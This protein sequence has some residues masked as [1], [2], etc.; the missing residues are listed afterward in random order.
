M[1][2]QNNHNGQ[3]ER[4][5]AILIKI[6]RNFA[7][8]DHILNSHDLRTWISIHI[9]RRTLMLVTV[10]EKKYNNLMSELLELLLCWVE[11]DWHIPVK[12]SS[13]VNCL[14]FYYSKQMSR[15]ISVFVRCF[16]YVDHSWKHDNPSK[17]RHQI[18]IPFLTLT[19]STVVL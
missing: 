12:L 18:A 17:R 9:T 4:W 16:Q 3:I 7:L 19:E 14:R 11:N 10:R 2:V 1:T 6:S 13:T 5:T 8:G 15:M